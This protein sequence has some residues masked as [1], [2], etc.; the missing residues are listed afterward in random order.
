MVKIEIKFEQVPILVKSERLPSQNK[1]IKTNK[2]LTRLPKILVRMWGTGKEPLYTVVAD[3]NWCD[4]CAIKYIFSLENW[5]TTIDPII[6]LLSITKINHRLHKINYPVCPC[7]LQ[8]YSHQQRHRINKCAHQFKCIKSMMWCTYVHTFSSHFIYS[9]KESLSEGFFYL[10]WGES[11][12]HSCEL[13]I[14][15]TVSIELWI[16][17]CFDQHHFLVWD[18]GLYKNG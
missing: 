6:S 17:I 9:W 5:I 15:L 4:H 13:R 8:H 12:D 3:I 1:Q 10:R 18:A 2:K 7:L 14:V 11:V 16:S